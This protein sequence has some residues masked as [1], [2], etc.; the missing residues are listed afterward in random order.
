[1]NILDKF[2]NI[3]TSL[4]PIGLMV[5]KDFEKYFCTPKEAIVF[6]HTGVDGIHYCIIP[7][8][9]DS[10]LEKSPVYEISPM[11]FENGIVLVG[12]NFIDFLSLI[13]SCRDVGMLERVRYTPKG[14][15]NGDIDEYLK[16]I[17]EMHEFE[18]KLEKAIEAI[19]DTFSISQID[20]VYDHIEQTNNNLEFYAK[21][22]F[23]DEYY[24]VTG[25][26]RK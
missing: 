22:S 10:S 5:S 14:K 13:V 19:K 12:R 9:N 23:S 21:Y 18:L 20:D 11:D 26:T 25:E 1:M 2:F 7:K 15:F 4:E 17:K 24:D 6:A 3:G 16:E 8:E